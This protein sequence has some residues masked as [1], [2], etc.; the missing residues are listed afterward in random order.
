MKSSDR[1][2][3]FARKALSNFQYLVE[4]YP[5]SIFTEKAL[6]KIPVC[7]QSLAEH[8]FLVGRFYYKKAN[9]RGAVGRFEGVLNT[10]SDT[11]VAPKALYYM[12][13]AFMKLSLPD[14]AKE[15]F[16]TITSRYSDSDY[17]ARAKEILRD[18]WDE[19]GAATRRESPEESMVAPL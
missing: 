8:E 4:N 11:D 13:K 19:T 18:E 12:G 3:A 17:Y 1:D 9:Y 7:R 15:A 10:F 2:S 16:L 5:P 6:E 14:K